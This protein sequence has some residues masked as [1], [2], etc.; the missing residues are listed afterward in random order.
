MKVETSR[1]QLEYFEDYHQ[2]SME[3][4]WS[5]WELTSLSYMTFL[6]PCMESLLGWLSM[7]E[8]KVGTCSSERCGIS[9][10]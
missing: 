8:C 4:A 10:S 5:Y 2:H 3:K 6:A 7:F 1:E 9:P